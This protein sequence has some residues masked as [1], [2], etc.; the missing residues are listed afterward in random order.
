M[1]EIKVG[2]VTFYKGCQMFTALSLYK[3]L[4]KQG[5]KPVATGDPK[6]EIRWAIILQN[7]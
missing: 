5:Q 3:N 2:N 6:A 1:I 7:L 4:E